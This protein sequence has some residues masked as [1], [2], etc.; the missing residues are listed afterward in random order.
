[1]KTLIVLSVVMAVS[2]CAGSSFSPSYAQ[3]TARDDTP[4][5]YHF[6]PGTYVNGWPRFTVHYP[7][8]WVERLPLVFETFEAAPAEP[9]S[10]APPGMG[11]PRG[12]VITV[13]GVRYVPLDKIAESAVLFLKN[14][15]QDVKLIYNK[16]SRLHDGTPAYEYETALLVKDTWW[17]LT[18]L[19]TVKGNMQIGLNVDHRSEKITDDLKGILYSVEFEPEKDKPV[20][21]PPDVQEFFDKVDSDAVSHDIAR[22][23]SHYSDRFLNSGTRKAEVERGLRQGIGDITSAKAVLTDFVPAGDKAY[24]TGYVNFNFGRTQIYETTIIKEN[25]EWKWYGNQREVA[26]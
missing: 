6:V 16:P 24:L 18:T 25:G 19:V 1:M 23:V 5:F 3:T 13:N 7:K 20:K 4:T 12:L 17:F 14:M 15:L 22:V 9:V 2:L 10:D 21:V 26:P 11:M 8:D